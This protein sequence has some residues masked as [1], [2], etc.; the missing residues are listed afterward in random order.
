MRWEVTEEA[1]RMVSDCAGQTNPIVGNKER[2]FT[3][4][5]LSCLVLLLESGGTA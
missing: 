1:D 3:D 4:K 2:K 5:K